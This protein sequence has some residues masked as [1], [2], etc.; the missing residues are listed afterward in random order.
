MLSLF[1]HDTLSE[2]TL[3]EDIDLDS[4]IEMLAYDDLSRQDTE[5]L[6]EFCNS[7]QARVLQEKQVLK[8]GTMVRLSKQDDEKRRIKL[9]AYKLA[10]DDK[11]S[12]WKKMVYHRKEWR[13]YRDRLMAHYG[14]RAEKIARITQREYIK[15]AQKS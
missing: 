2:A 11:S 8:K 3:L 5:S 7:E 13:K 15:K 4:Y 9:C 12:D 1:G 6:Q 10:R 14:R